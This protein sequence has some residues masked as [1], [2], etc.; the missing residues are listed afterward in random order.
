MTYTLTAILINVPADLLLAGIGVWNYNRA[1]NHA[2]DVVL[3]KKTDDAIWNRAMRKANLREGKRFAKKE[4][5]RAALR[6]VFLRSLCEN[7]CTTEE[8]AGRL[9]DAVLRSN[10]R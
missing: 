8:L 2:A 3:S 7:D 6:S 10:I 9:A 1:L 5:K 4:E